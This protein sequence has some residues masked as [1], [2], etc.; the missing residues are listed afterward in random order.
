MVASEGA[1]SANELAALAADKPLILADNVL[2]RATAARWTLTGTIAGAD[3]SDVDHPP[4]MAWDGHLYLGTFPATAQTDHYYLNVTLAADE[5]FDCLFLKH[6]LVPAACTLDIQACSPNDW[7]API[8]LWSQA[9][10]SINRI[11]RLSLNGAG[12]ANRRFTDFRN[13]RLH[14]HAGAAFAPPR[15]GELVLARRRQLSGKAWYPYDDAP[16]G[17]LG[18]TYKARGRARKRH[19]FA[20]RFTD[21]KGTWTVHDGNYGLDDVSTI[22]DLWRECADGDW[23]VVYIEEPGSNASKALFS[24]FQSDSDLKELR[25]ERQDVSERRWDVDLTEL[26]PFAD[27]DLVAAVVQSLSSFHWPQ[28]SP[29]TSGYVD[30]G[31]PGTFDGIASATWS[32]WTFSDAFPAGVGFLIGVYEY[33]SAAA[34]QFLFEIDGLGRLNFSLYGGVNVDTRSAVGVA[35]GGWHHW[36]VTWDGALGWPHVPQSDAIK[37]YLDGAP[38]GVTFLG[39]GVPTNLNGPVVTHLGLGRALGVGGA[40]QLVTTFIDEPAMWPGVVGS[41]GQAAEIR[42]AGVPS[43]LAACSLG[44]PAHW[45][46][47]D[48]D[49]L[50]NVLDHGTGNANGIASGTIEIAAEAPP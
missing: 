3:V 43:D 10:T 20:G 28:A 39:G 11:V 25:L 17:G 21:V 47:A 18:A 9:L 29:A 38:V 27:P 16:S 46:R 31:N 49:V 44:R 30:C 41:A 36:F 15:I 50:P 12:G 14:Y 22:R 32:L 13:F 1:V 2:R 5:V 45:Y 40:F 48:G 37:M 23:P 6:T 35:T 4:W 8:T 34:S 42:N 26:P 19:R 24:E 33:S 7:S